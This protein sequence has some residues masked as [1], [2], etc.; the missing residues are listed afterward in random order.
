MTGRRLS[1][2]TRWRT[3][4]HA[5]APAQRSKL[6]RPFCADDAAP[7]LP[8][9]YY[10]PQTRGRR[11]RDSEAFNLIELQVH[12]N[13]RCQTVLEPIREAEMVQAIDRVRPVLNRRKIFVLNN[14]PLDLTVDRAMTWPELRPSIL[15]EVVDDA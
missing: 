9:G 8:V 5:T 3:L 15:A 13:A 1:P 4:S 6:T 12:F 7:F 10:V 14:L 11:M 2:S